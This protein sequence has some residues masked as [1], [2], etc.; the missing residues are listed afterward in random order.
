MHPGVLVSQ[1]FI[2]G[3]DRYNITH[4]TLAWWQQNHPDWIQYA[5]TSGGAPT[6]DIA[7]MGG[8]NEPDMPIDIHNPSAVA[9]HLQ[10]LAQAAKNAG[11]TALAIDQVVFWNIDKGGNPSF[12]QRVHSSEYACGSW[13]GNTFQRAYASPT[14]PQFATDVV[15][16][17]AQ[18][19]AIAHQYGLTLIVNHPA[20]PVSNANEQRLLENTDI[21]MD[22]TGF[23]DYGHYAQQHGEIFKNELAYVRYAQ[24]HNTGVFVIDKFTNE[25][26]VDARSF[27]YSLATYL[28]GNEGGMLLFVGGNKEYGTMQYHSEY[29]APIGHPCTAVNS[30]PVVFSRRFSG[31]LAVVNAGASPQTFTLPS[32]SYRDV[33]GR[34]I[35]GGS[36]SL[37]PNDGYVL[38]GGSGC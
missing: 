12:G 35:G 5:C 26:H 18:A 30:G 3:M 4:H 22:E 8:I 29:D 25:T 2:M 16:Y 7:Y 31:G 14:D 1:Y 10:T 38:L 33:E 13:H 28:L 9:Y 19:R 6:H 17:V 27:E 11:Y 34:A 36:L 24:E 37:A 32:G 15:N 21:D 23:S 20:G